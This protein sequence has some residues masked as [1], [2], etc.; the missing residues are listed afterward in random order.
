MHDNRRK[1]VP[2]TRAKKVNW[3][4]WVGPILLAGRP[5][6]ADEPASTTDQWKHLQDVPLSDLLNLEVTSVSKSPEKLFEAAS[7]ISVVSGDDIRRS[8][9]RSIP[10][11]LRLVPGMSVAR[12][13]GNTWAISPRGFTSVFADKMLV[14][15][16][17]R[18]V[19][20]PAFNGVVWNVQDY[21][22][23]DI[24]RI[25]VIRGP[26]GTLWGANAV[27]GVV[28]IIT[29]G[30]KETQG[31]YLS[32]G[33]GT[34][35]HGMASI[36]YGAKLGDDADGRAYFNYHEHGP[37]DGGNDSGTMYQGGFRTDWRPSDFSTL[38]FQGD[39]YSN[40]RESRTVV[41]NYIGPD[42]FPLTDHA[43]RYEGG[44]AM[45][46]YTLETGAD[47]QV[48][49]QAYYD[50]ADRREFGITTK[51]AIID[52]DLQHHFALGDRQKVIY[53]AGYRYYPDDSPD[54]PLLDYAHEQRDPQLFSLF[55]QD[56]IAVIQDRVKLT[57]GTKVEHNDVTGFEVQP[58]ARLAWMPTDRQTVWGAVSRAVQLPGPTV[59]DISVRTLALPPMDAGGGMNLFYRG[60]PSL[61]PKSQTLIAYELGY[62]AQVNDKVTFDLAGYYNRY[63]NLVAGSPGT[64]FLE[65][66]PTPHYVLP[67]T[68]VN[69]GTEDTYGFEIG[70]QWEATD[71]WRLS[72]WYSSFHSKVNAFLQAGR[73]PENQVSLRSSLDLGNNVEFD[74]WGRYVDVLPAGVPG[75][76]RVNPYFGLDARIAWRPSKRLELAVVG[77][78]LITPYHTEFSP[79]VAVLSQITRVP[80]GV[81]ATVTLRF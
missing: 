39:G 55:A 70:A 50:R 26:G 36:R 63:R 60:Y 23:E 75:G 65:L 38:T 14:L 28:N 15:V 78:N 34:T 20:S 13:D 10:E 7:A 71:T 17:G 18:T 35:E 48:Q 76:P 66:T 24:D 31:G 47:S 51:Q 81:Y 40:L 49:A 69:D 19:Y 56:E 2:T 77:Q 8:G 44:N 46:R 12:A 22:L 54:T 30:S 32:G 5:L 52:V 45:V 72:A 1:A 58:N 57:L 33:G 73:D 4:A 79:D 9:V 16:D 25:E 80:R 53:G 43:T 41:P 62:R 37:F 29:K 21:L 59:T 68:A 64:A 74:L 42:F 61:H 3:L 11:A 6:A 67:I 27:N